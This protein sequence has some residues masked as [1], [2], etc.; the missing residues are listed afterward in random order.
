ML[1]VVCDLCG[2]EINTGK[3]ER[4]IIKVMK[5][6]T[7]MY[8]EYDVCD[9]CAKQ[10]PDN[11]RPAFTDNAEIEKSSIEKLINEARKKIF[12]PYEYK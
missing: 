9:K 1:K 12:P 2:E 8:E 3:D 11:I 4:Y 5:Y 6:G 7:L 10:L